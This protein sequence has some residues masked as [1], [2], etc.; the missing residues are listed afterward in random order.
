M[1]KP[2]DINVCLCLYDDTQHHISYLILSSFVQL[3]QL[4]LCATQS[5]FTCDTQQGGSGQANGCSPTSIQVGSQ[6]RDVMLWQTD[7]CCFLVRNR[8]ILSYCVK[9]YHHPSS[10]ICDSFH[11]IQ[12]PIQQNINIYQ[13]FEYRSVLLCDLVLFWF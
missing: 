6:Q 7:S 3:Q 4:L 2:N 12:N 1:H 11:H 10:L 9:Q 13:G 5:L 8:E